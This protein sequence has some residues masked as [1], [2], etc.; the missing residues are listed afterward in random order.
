MRRVDVVV[1]GGGPA[2]AACA[3]GLVHRGLD[4]VV[5]DRARFPRVKLCGGLVTQEAAAALGLHQ[6]DYPHGWLWIDRFHFHW[7][8]LRLPLPSPQI[9]IRRVEFDAFLLQRS[10]AELVHH[11]VQT[12]ERQGGGYV[13]DG[14]WRADVVVGAG[15]TACPVY[16]TF[17]R[18]LGLREKGL[19]IT[20]LELEFA[21]EVRERDCHFWFFEE[22]FPGY[23]W[24]IPKAEGWVNV[25]VGALA[26]PLKRAQDNIWRHWQRCLAKLQAL[27]WLAG[28]VP[29]PGGHTYYLMGRPARARRDGVYLV[30]DAAGLA[31]RDLGEGIRAAIESGLRAAAAIADGGDYRLDD[32]ARTSWPALL[33]G[34]VRRRWWA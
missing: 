31:T 34:L 30:G 26:E 33:R 20:A 11:R 10:G 9:S 15:G 27:G 29:Q 22:G 16:R 1:V 14:Q 12:I 17:F 25:G 5:L 23:Y 32:L 24:Y 28:E 13:V 6:A 2:G 21:H 19:Q 18:E 7:R 4:V 8:G 3:T